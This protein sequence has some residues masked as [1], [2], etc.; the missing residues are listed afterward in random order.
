MTSKTKRLFELKNKLST[1]TAKCLYPHAMRATDS[2]S[3][4]SPRLT[5][6]LSQLKNGFA[7]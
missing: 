1:I 7:Q 5:M 6:A 3:V 2:R 4:S